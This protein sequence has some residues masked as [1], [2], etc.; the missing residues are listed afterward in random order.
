MCS[1]RDRDTKDDRDRD[2]DDRDRRENGTNGD[3]RKGICALVQQTSK[4]ALT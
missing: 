1:D 3:D 4:L 2:R